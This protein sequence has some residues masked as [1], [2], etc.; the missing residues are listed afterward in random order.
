MKQIALASLVLAACGVQASNPGNSPFGKPLLCPAQ[1][2]VSADP[3][4]ALTAAMDAIQAQPTPA[5][6]KWALE[7]VES[8]GYPA[9]TPATADAR[10][11][12]QRASWLAKNGFLVA[13]NMAHEHS[14]LTIDSYKRSEFA[15]SFRN[16]INA[17]TQPV[18]HAS[19]P[20]SVL[21]KGEKPNNGKGDHTH[22]FDLEQAS[23]ALDEII[24]RVAVTKQ[25][26]KDEYKRAPVRHYMLAQGFRDPVALQ[27]ATD[28]VCGLNMDADKLTRFNVSARYMA[29]PLVPETKASKG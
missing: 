5:D 24:K 17:S 11:A 6:L 8:S 29:M 15:S 2:Q 22:G 7:M 25:A 4:S 27:A 10:G 3:G 20:S 19:Y 23:L 14:V 1:K 12:A 13:A 9:H 21:A 16:F 28:M 26:L 18:H